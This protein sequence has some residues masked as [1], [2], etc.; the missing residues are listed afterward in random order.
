MAKIVN[1]EVTGDET[2]RFLSLLYR[3]AGKVEDANSPIDIIRMLGGNDLALIG[4]YI[5]DKPVGYILVEPQGEEA[6]MLQAYSQDSKC[7]KPMFRYL[8][9]WAL[10]QGFERVAG[11]T[12]R[13]PKAWK[14]KYDLDIIEY[15]IGKELIDYGIE[16]SKK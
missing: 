10:K 13:S 6:V 4:S 12:K 3:Y 7:S 14:R 11:Y 1:S 9:K 16:A 5:N 15:K 8:C 2:Y